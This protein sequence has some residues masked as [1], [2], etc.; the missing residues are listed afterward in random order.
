[1]HYFRICILDIALVW[2]WT[3]C[4]H[5]WKVSGFITDICFFVKQFYGPASCDCL[6]I[7]VNLTLILSCIN[8]RGR[9]NYSYYHV[10]HFIKHSLFSSHSSPEGRPFSHTYRYARRRLHAVLQILNIYFI[11]ALLGDE[12]DMFKMQGSKKRTTNPVLQTFFKDHETLSG[13]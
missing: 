4:Y 1:M 10:S 13:R 7:I 5:R 8:S 12:V 9:Y 11:Q 6:K 2:L 3:G